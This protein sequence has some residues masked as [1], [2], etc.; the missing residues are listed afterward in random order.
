MVILII[1][2]TNDEEETKGKTCSIYFPI[3]HCFNYRNSDYIILIIKYSYIQQIIFPE[4]LSSIIYLLSFIIMKNFKMQEEDLIASFRPDTTSNPALQPRQ[5]YPHPVQPHL[6]HPNP[7]QHQHQV[8]VTP[9]STIAVHNN[10][11]LQPQQMHH[12]QNSRNVNTPVVFS[13]QQ[14]LPQ[15]N[16]GNNSINT[17]SREQSQ[18]GQIIQTVNAPSIQVAAP[19]AVNNNPQS[20]IS[21]QKQPV[22]VSQ[23][24]NRTVSNQPPP[25]NVVYQN[26]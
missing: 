19:Q 11:H 24:Q 16:N 9:H 8:H 5:P 7:S 15:Q 1:Y 14:P 18:N 4:H 21:M 6:Y 26:I 20:N 25:Q 12:P 13:I 3:A 2:G 23:N 22:V 10:P 17:G